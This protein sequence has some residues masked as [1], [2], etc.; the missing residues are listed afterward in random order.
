VAELQARLEAEEERSG[1]LSAQAA[2]AR[3]QLD[4]GRS[5]SAGDAEERLRAAEAQAEELAR[6]AVSAETR[7][8]ELD[9]FAALG[10][11]VSVD[12]AVPAQ[13]AEPEAL[14]GLQKE[15]AEARNAAEAAEA[16]AAELA[17]ELQAV[18]WEKDELEQKL[19]AGAGRA[20]SA[21]VSK[22]RDEL[23]ERSAD[24]AL[25]RRDVDRLE[26]V[27]A[28]LS[29][30]EVPQAGDPA[31]QAQLADA[32]QRAADAEAALAAQR[33]GADGADLAALQRAAQ[34][35]DSVAAQLAERDGKIAR[36]QREVQ[37][38]TERLGR[39]AKELGELK[40]KGLGKIFR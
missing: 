25:A 39:L 10:V 6:R 1:I 21:E 35:R 19:Q 4:G 28:S 9:A 17:A 29:I 2:E 11:T 26:A 40:A 13:L 7:A 20:S 38:K 31:L 12:E 32:L 5:G 8:R 36:L 24:L 37:D 18:R 34:E 15:L 23:A 27:V 16:S 14:Q 30:Q 22:L 33:P 3:A